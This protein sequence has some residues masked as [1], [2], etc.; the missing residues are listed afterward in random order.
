MPPPAEPSDP[1]CVAWTAHP[2]RQRPLAAA[3]AIIVIVAFSLLA[4]DLGGHSLWGIASALVLCLSLHHFFFASR[5]RID[6][7]GVHAE[8]LFGSRSLDWDEIRRIDIGRRGAWCSTFARRHMLEYR[9]GVLLLFGPQRDAALAALR[10]YGR[11]RIAPCG[12][13]APAG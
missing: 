6:R 5:Y 8:T 11:S 3:A 10:H 7:T 9:R 1:P 13:D 4:A 12:A 2:A